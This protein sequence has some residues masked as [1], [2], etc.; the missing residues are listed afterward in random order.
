M[1]T[2]KYNVIEQHQPLRVPSSFDRQGKQLVIQIDELLDDIYKRFGRLG[3]KDMSSEFRFVIDN[4]YDRISG[5][6]IDDDGVNIT[7][8][9][10]VEIQAGL[11]GGTWTYD[12]SGLKY[13]KEGDPLPFQFARYEDR[14]DLTSGVFYNFS[15][16]GQTGEVILLA[17]CRNGIN[18]SPSG[19]WRGE[20]AYA[21]TDSDDIDAEGNI[22]VFYPKASKGSLGTR[23]YPWTFVFARHILGKNESGQGVVSIVPNPERAKRQM[24][25]NINTAE[26]TDNG[27]TKDILWIDGKS[28]LNQFLI[29][30]LA[31]D[32]NRLEG[33]TTYSGAKY[34]NGA[35]GESY[36]YF[37]PNGAA[38]KQN[39]R[40][41]I[42]ETVDSSDNQLIQVFGD[43]GGVY[44]VD[45]YGRL[46]GNVS[47]NVTGN[48][49]GDLTGDVT[50]NLNGSIVKSTGSV[51]IYPRGTSNKK[52][53]I[54]EFDSSGTR[55]VKIWSDGGEFQIEN[56]KVTGTFSGNIVK[57]TG[58]IF[59]YPNG[60]NDK[61]LQTYLY[62][63]N[64]KKIMQISSDADKLTFRGNAD[65]ATK[66]SRAPT[67]GELSG[68]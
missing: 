58:L 29:R 68:R 32:S 5:I 34:I 43:S 39:V 65:S 48:V 50:G 66:L 30:G 56:A 8:N 31:T 22:G 15:Q 27:V 63:D 59:A 16:T 10:Y 46:V 28:D 61:V 49:T 37:R 36:L 38:G 21:M 55:V 9:K 13:Y 14:E 25:I 57:T 20:A 47:G 23:T 12:A 4:K 53:Q 52:L 17:E 3:M 7:G 1:S 54:E 60:T 62:T 45:Y 26:Y 41:V 51:Q 2:N 6:T 18:T 67:Y 11:G 64:N 33:F 19:F 24:A 35:S 40:L 44:R 42:R